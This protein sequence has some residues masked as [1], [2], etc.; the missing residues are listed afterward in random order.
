MMNHFVL[1]IAGYQPSIF[2]WFDVRTFQKFQEALRKRFRID[3]LKEFV[4]YH[5]ECLV[6]EELYETLYENRLSE[7]VK[8][9][10]RGDLMDNISKERMEML[11][12][13]DCTVKVY[14]TTTLTSKNIVYEFKPH[15]SSTIRELKLALQANLRID[16]ISEGL[17]LSDIDAP[18]GH[19]QI[20]LLLPPH[21]CSFLIDEQPIV[22]LL[23]DLPRAQPMELKVLFPLNKE[24]IKKY[25]MKVI[26]LIEIQISDLNPMSLDILL[27]KLGTFS[28]ID[29]K[30]WI[31]KKFK[32]P[33]NEQVFTL[34]GLEMTDDSFGLMMVDKDAGQYKIDVSIFSTEDVDLQKVYQQNKIKTMVSARIFG[35]ISSGDVLATYHFRGQEGQSI[36]NY[37]EEIFKIPIKN[38]IMFY[39]NIRI[40]QEQLIKQLKSKQNIRRIV[41]SLEV[42]LSVQADDNE[43][44]LLPIIQELNLKRLR[45]VIVKHP[46]K[47]TIFLDLQLQF[48]DLDLQVKAKIVLEIERKGVVTEI[49]RHLTTEWADGRIE[50]LLSVTEYNNRAYG[51]LTIDEQH[52]G[53]G[54]LTLE[55]PFKNVGRRKIR[56]LVSPPK[57]NRIFPW[58]FRYRPR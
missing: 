32:D 40:T 17:H 44:E 56:F 20:R 5:G 27:P 9:E 55:T 3:P 53:S 13:S 34:S 16:L 38:Q 42:I 2:Y 43:T 1:K 18:S 26:P 46:T 15:I 52:F 21:Y 45:S 7:K 12:R 10:A 58:G 36:G 51:Y 8:F 47:D 54:G 49:E 19:S 24:S 31:Q 35:S 25:K 50:D 4:V 57:I 22:D 33:I 29:L 39:N 30:Y 28:M 11:K 48:L 14:R 41:Q 23:L 37:L 6:T